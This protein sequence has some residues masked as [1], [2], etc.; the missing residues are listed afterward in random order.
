MSY[1]SIDK[2]QKTLAENVFH[3]TKDAKK[4]S[5]RA[6]GTLVEIITFYLIKDWGFEGG[7]RIEKRLVEYSNDKISHNVEYSIHPTCKQIQISIKKDLPIT[8]KKIFQHLKKKILSK[9]ITG[10]SMR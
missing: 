4:A 6:L 5:G 10:K 1:S 7:I 3:Y 2:L 8:T 9:K